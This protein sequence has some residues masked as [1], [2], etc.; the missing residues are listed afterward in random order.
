[1][2]HRLSTPPINIQQEWQNALQ[3]RYPAEVEETGRPARVPQTVVHNQERAR[4]DASDEMR[5]VSSPHSPNVQLYMGLPLAPVQSVL[6]ADGFSSDFPAILA[7][8]LQCSYYWPQHTP[9]SILIHKYSILASCFCTEKPR[10][11]TF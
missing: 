9:Y 3:A 5:A 10:K 11:V 7:T 6:S 2:S 8:Y 1:M 4:E